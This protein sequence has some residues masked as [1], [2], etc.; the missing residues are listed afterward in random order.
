MV[1]KASEKKHSAWPPLVQ[2]RKQI[3]SANQIRVTLAPDN[4]RRRSMT[5]SLL[6]NKHQASFTRHGKVS[7]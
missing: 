5:R 2:E 4:C 6:L 3:V 1:E 7:P